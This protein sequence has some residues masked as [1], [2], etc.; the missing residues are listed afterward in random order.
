MGGTGASFCWDAWAS[1]AVRRKELWTISN[2]ASR[3]RCSRLSTPGRVIF[4]RRSCLVAPADRSA[5]LMRIVVC[6]RVLAAG[7]RADESLPGS[8]GCVPEST[9]GV[10]PSPSTNI[11]R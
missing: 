1:V 11:S 8:V 6:P 7:C 10:S 5:N 3:V 2:C 9:D 4:R